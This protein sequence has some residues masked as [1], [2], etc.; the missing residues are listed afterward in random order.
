MISASLHEFLTCESG[1]K[2]VM[3]CGIAGSGKSTLAKAIASKYDFIRLSMDQIV[4][5]DH[6]LYGIDYDPVRYDDLLD[7]ADLKINKRLRQ[8]LREKENVVLDRSFWSLE[9]RKDCYK[10]LGEEQVIAHKLVYLQASKD[11]LWDSIQTRRTEPLN[12]NNAKEISKEEFEKYYSGFNVPGEDED[13]EI[14]DV[15]AVRTKPT[16]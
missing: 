10:L 15:E 16:T 4:A 5:D 8:L 1:P 13:V 3:M 14:I 7:E 12:A 9:D 2:V 11:F 6:G